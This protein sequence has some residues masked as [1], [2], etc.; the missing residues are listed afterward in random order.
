MMVVEEEGQ[1]GDTT[2]QRQEP[3]E[4]KTTPHPSQS[5][6]ISNQDTEGSDGQVLWTS[7]PH[8]GPSQYLCTAFGLYQVIVP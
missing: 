3:T 1:I 4:Y 6:V 7:L 8:P 5:R 2:E